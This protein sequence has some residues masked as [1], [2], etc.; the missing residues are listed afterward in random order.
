MAMA[1][2]PKPDQDERVKIDLPFEDA[3]RGVLKVD[4][5][6]PHTDASA[7]ENPCPKTWMGKKC[8]LSAGHFGPCQFQA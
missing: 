6:A 8:K 5:D 1:E 2:K 4:P 7:D 3:V